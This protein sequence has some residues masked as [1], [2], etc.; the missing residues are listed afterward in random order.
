MFDSSTLVILLFPGEKKKAHSYC[1]SQIEIYNL[2]TRVMFFGCKAFLFSMS[3]AHI[4]N[5]LQTFHSCLG[6][7]TSENTEDVSHF[8]CQTA[9]DMRRK[10]SHLVGTEHGRPPSD[11][12]IKQIANTSASERGP[13]QVMVF[14]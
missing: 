11:T 14:Q 2:L 8:G 12:S 3:L 1:S 6:N 10:E 7:L 13:R 4:G 5:L 9:S